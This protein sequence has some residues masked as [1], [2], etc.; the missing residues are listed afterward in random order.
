MKHAWRAYVRRPGS[1][2][3]RVLIYAASA[4]TVGGMLF[5]ILHILIGGVPHLRASLFSLRYTVEN[6][7]MLP[8]IWN[9]LVMTGMTL[10]IAVPLGIFLRFIL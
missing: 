6:V 8:A 5:L 2:I 1:L 9:T 3:L 4:L 10:L 7:S